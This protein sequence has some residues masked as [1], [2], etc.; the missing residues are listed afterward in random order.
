MKLPTLFYWTTLL[1]L[2]LLL[3]THPLFSKEDP[4]IEE[5]EEERQVTGVFDRV[6]NEYAVIL[7]EE[8]QTEILTPLTI[9]PP[10]SKAGVL[11]TIRIGDF[12]EVVEID[13]T[14]TEK[15]EETTSTLM[16]RLKEKAYKKEK[17]NN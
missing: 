14:A 3:I 9:L 16:L 5:P 1:L 11:F 2:F 17:R 7:I 6:E 8:Q 12:T 15:A 4:I 10:G 13:E